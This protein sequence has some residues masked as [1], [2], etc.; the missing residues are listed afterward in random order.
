MGYT[1]SIA[2]LRHPKNV[3]SIGSKNYSVFLFNFLSLIYMK[4]TTLILIGCALLFVLL[5]CVGGGIGAYLLFF[6]TKELGSVEDQKAFIQDAE[7]ALTEK[8]AYAAKAEGT[9]SSGKALT[10]EIKVSGDDYSMS[11]EQSG[12]KMEFVILGDYVYMSFGGKWAKMDKSSGDSYTSEF[13]DIKEEFSGNMYDIEDSDWDEENIKYEGIEE[14]DGI[15][16][17]KFSMKT[18]DMDGY[19]WID[20]KTKLAHKATS[21]Q[22]GEKMTIVFS[23]SD[24]K[25][26]APS[27]YED[28]TGLSEEEAGMKLL[29]I[30][31]G[32]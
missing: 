2:P 4:G 25:V 28:L 14:V 11:M 8:D 24:V 7:K 23:Y 17:H 10:A 30:M 31:G 15:K 19:L 3:Y 13:S 22:N 18:T 5:L 29:E 12:Q 6:N 16:C 26:K 21:D 20:T 27:D 1:M 9:D 32:Y